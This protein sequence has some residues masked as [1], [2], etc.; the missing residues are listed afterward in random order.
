[1]WPLKP[2]WLA[3]TR[4]EGEGNTGPICLFLSGDVMPGRGIDQI[5]P[6]PVDPVLYERY[7]RDARD[8]IDLA[9][10][11]HGPIPRPVGFDYIWGDALQEFERL[12]PDARI[13]NLETA[14]TTSGQA[15]PKG[16]NYRMHP[17]NIGCITAGQIDCCCLA[18][19][20]VLDWGSAGLEETTTTLD[21]AGVRHAGAGSNLSEAAAPVV[22]DIGERGRVLVCAVGSPTS[23]I[24]HD[25]GASDY[26]PGLYFV[27]VL[28]KETAHPVASK[29]Q[30]FKQFGDIAIVSVHWGGNWGY[31]VPES[32][33]QFAHRLIDEGIDVVHGHSSHHVKPIEIYKDHLIL[34]G[35][36]DF[37][38][39]Y[40]GITGYEEY[41]GGLAVMYLPALE[42]F[43]GRLLQLRMV[44]L[45]SNRFRLRAASISDVL[46]LR[47][48]FNRIC[49]PYGT[50]VEPDPGETLGL[51]LYCSNSR[52]V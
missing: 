41:R 17:L 4:G 11:V 49:A 19:N 36:G 32:Q 28:S 22:I 15:Y 37:L 7:V 43:S 52:T 2:N 16:I 26:G 45:Q 25:W 39:D 35:C 3:R 30:R 47:N 18:N 44:V 40:E 27:E 5:L 48:L 1:M 10:S 31:E 42:P 8:Y 6:H 46:W 24:P 9:E 38:T 14:I 33:R 29:I 13:I 50:R 23:G 20:H 34:Y 51:T 12:A 21:R